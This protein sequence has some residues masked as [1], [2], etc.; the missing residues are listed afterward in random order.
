MQTIG[1]TALAGTVE[2]DASDQNVGRENLIAVDGVGKTYVT[3]DGRSIQAVAS[4]NV[5]I[6]KGEFLSILGPSGCGKSTLLMMIAGLV[7]PSEGVIRFEGKPVTDPH[8]DAG[9]VFQ[10]AV[11]F[12]WRTVAQNVELPGEIRRV[13]RDA[14]VKRSLD[15]LE[16]VGLK[17]FETKYPNELSGGMQQRV[18]IARALSMQPNLIL[19]DEPFGAL[20]AMT[21]DQMNLDLQRIS[22]ETGATIVF[23]THSIAEAAFLSDRVCVMSGRPSTIRA[24]VPIEI[25]RPRPIEMM[26]SDEMGRY[27]TELRKLLDH[28]GG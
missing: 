11:L 3:Q 9:V 16:L 13:R 27:V 2:T 15:V 23:V 20:D 28:R 12:P 26:A 21:R 1:A 5:E 19:M 8:G 10:D 18:S 17:G 22:L 6:A 25:P 4:V 24:I 7:K 14:R